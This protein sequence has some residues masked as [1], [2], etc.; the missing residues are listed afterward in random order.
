M[1]SKNYLVDFLQSDLQDIEKILNLYHSTASK[2]EDR[3]NF[4]TLLDTVYYWQTHAK[5]F[6]QQ[7]QD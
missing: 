6:K 3:Q 5:S 7:E 1:S 2:E 4:S